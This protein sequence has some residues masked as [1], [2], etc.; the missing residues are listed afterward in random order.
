MSHECEPDG[1]NLIRTGAGP[2]QREPSHCC[3][4]SRPSVGRIDLSAESRVPG[5]SGPASRGHTKTTKHTLAPMPR[6][7]TACAPGRCPGLKR[8]WNSN[9]RADRC[10]SRI[11]TRPSFGQSRTVGRARRPTGVGALAGNVALPA[12]LPML[13][14]RSSSRSSR[15]SSL[16]TL[17]F[18]SASRNSMAAGTS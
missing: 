11:S 5:P 9:G 13:F 12:Q 16:P 7:P 18:G 4:S 2:R 6:L 15:R 3:N 14:L 17:D 10:G 1:Q 8:D